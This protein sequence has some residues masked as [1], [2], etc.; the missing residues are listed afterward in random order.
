MR[1]ATVDEKKRCPKCGPIGGQV[2]AGS[3]RSGTQQ[4]L[5]AFP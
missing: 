1:K 3:D 5:T 4:M 2:K